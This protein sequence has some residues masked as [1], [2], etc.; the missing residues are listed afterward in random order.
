MP[1]SP[2]NE[3][4]R[5]AFRGAVFFLA[6]QLSGTPDTAGPPVLEDKAARLSFVI[7]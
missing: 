6:D 4:D 7:D 3:R 5:F 1:V 2:A